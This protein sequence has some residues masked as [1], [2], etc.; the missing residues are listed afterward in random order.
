MT[1]I[2]LNRE[3]Q[4][5]AEKL[6]N[7]IFRG[8][9]EA[10]EAETVTLHGD[11]QVTVVWRDGKVVSVST[12]IDTKEGNGRVWL[13]TGLAILTVIPVFAVLVSYGFGMEVFVLFLKLVAL[14]GGVVSTGCFALGA[15]YGGKST[16][17]ICLVFMT[18]TVPVLVSLIYLWFTDHFWFPLP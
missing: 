15:W 9:S 16:R 6:H 7:E 14:L 17:R 10:V 1:I 18:V 4:C 8:A 12:E 13:L 3:E 5:D 2:L 11:G